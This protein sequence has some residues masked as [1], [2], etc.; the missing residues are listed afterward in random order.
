MTRDLDASIV[1]DGRPGKPPAK[2]R[3]FP[4]YVGAPIRGR[5]EREDLYLLP[6]QECG[7]NES[8][9]AFNAAA[10]AWSALRNRA[11]KALS[12]TTSSPI[13]GVSSTK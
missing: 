8:V 1:V 5:N 9:H 2:R 4:A 3:A 10:W 12:A 11:S 6:L 13:G 7:V